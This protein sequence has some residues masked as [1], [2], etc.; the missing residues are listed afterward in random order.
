MWTPS[1]THKIHRKITTVKT[2]CKKHNL[3]IRVEEVGSPREDVHYFLGQDDLF[4]MHLHGLIWSRFLME[5]VQ[6]LDYCTVTGLQ[7]RQLDDVLHCKHTRSDSV[8]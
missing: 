8:C 5:D 6:S 2:E 7:G 3:C 4:L 1:L